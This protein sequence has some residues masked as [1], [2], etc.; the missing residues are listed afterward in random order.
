MAAFAIPALAAGAGVLGG[1][2]IG[3]GKK[4]STITHAPYE[5][6]APTFGA[7]TYSPVVSDVRQIEQSY[8]APTYIIESPKAEVKKSVTMGQKSAVDMT[9]T[10]NIPTTGSQREEKMSSGLDVTN[11]AIIAV[12]GAVAVT[13][14]GAFKSKGRR[15]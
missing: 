12:I 3:G 5:H 8:I 9:P 6:Y 15:K 1:M 10:W 13:A 11:I 2:L 14:V 7:Q 4:Q